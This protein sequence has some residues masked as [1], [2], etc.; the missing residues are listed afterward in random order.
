M[1]CVLTCE[2]PTPLHDGHVGL[3]PGVGPSCRHSCCMQ[4]P[5][6]GH[7][8]SLGE[9]SSW[10]AAF[11][12]H[13]ALASSGPPQDQD[14]S[15]PTRLPTRDAF[16]PLGPEAVTLPSSPPPSSPCTEPCTSPTPSA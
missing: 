9:A 5:M 14:D 12:P 4:W 2:I 15:T 16:G 3:G 6:A 1:K 7:L 13:A 10:G 11:P 8:G